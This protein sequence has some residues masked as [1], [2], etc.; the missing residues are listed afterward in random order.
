MSAAR[1]VCVIRGVIFPV[2]GGSSDVLSLMTW[3]HIR[4]GHKKQSYTRARARTVHSA[5]DAVTFAALLVG[6]ELVARVT[7]ALEA[8][9]SVYTPLLTSTIVW[10][11][12]LI[13]LWK[14]RTSVHV[15]RVCVRSR[16]QAK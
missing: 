1:G 11:G 13:L 15:V 4:P 6:S 2:D 10:L 7:G 9:Q 3:T 8:A 14:T 16:I 12:T 5:R